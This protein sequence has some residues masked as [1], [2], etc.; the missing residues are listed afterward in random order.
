[1]GGRNNLLGLLSVLFGIFGVGCCCCPWLN[2]APL[3]GGVP[4]L[5]LGFL[6]LQRVRRRQATNPALGWIGIALGVLSLCL[7]A[8]TFTSQF[9]DFQDDVTP[10]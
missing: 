3:F 1:M 4:A 2:G 8:A 6:H 7:G 9:G 5:V 10:Y